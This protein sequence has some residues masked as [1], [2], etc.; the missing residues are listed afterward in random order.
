MLNDYYHVTD[1]HAKGFTG[2]GASVAIIVFDTFEPSDIQVFS[3]RFH[4]P[5]ATINVIP[6]FGGAVHKGPAIDGVKEVTLDINMVHAAA[7][8][9]LINVYS[10]PEGLPFSV[11][12]Q[13]ILDE[14]KDQI[15][16]ISWAKMQNPQEDARCFQI[17]EEMSKRGITVFAATGDYGRSL[18]LANPLAPAHLPNV[19]AVGG[20]I[21]TADPQLNRITESD[22]PDSV[23]GW[24][25]A[26]PLPKY[27]S[28]ASASAKL[29]EESKKYRVIPDIVGPSVVKTSDTLTAE[30][31]GLLFYVTSPTTGKGEWG[32]IVGTSVASPY[33][34]GIFATIVGGLHKGLGDIHQQLYSMMK[35][36]AFN[37]VANADQAGTTKSENSFTQ[38]SGLGSLNAYEMAV[39]YG[40]IKNVKH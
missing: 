5:K 20:T 11:I 3:E 7:P 37:Q 2:K 30:H 18:E 19:V 38:T 40:L 28:A 26:Y 21:V 14:G 32:P 27:Q 1:V 31:G 25:M 15:V 34:A 4:L 6:L 9:A 23:R 8:D 35:S 39:A 10:A 17:I 29:A 22:W 33:I 24:T 36:A 13:K 16:T 12:F